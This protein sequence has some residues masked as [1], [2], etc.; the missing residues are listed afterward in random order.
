MGCRHQ[1]FFQVGGIV[2]RQPEPEIEVEDNLFMGIGRTDRNSAL[3]RSPE[4][5]A[6]QNVLAFFAVDH[7]EIEMAGVV[8]AGAA[9]ISRILIQT[10]RRIRDCTQVPVVRNTAKEV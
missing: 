5:L 10:D 8:R 9:S 3:S 1:S 7:A 6:P 4:G 2:K